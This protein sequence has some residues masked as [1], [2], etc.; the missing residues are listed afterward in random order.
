MC[1]CKAGYAGNGFGE[2]GCLVATSD[3]CNFVRCRNGGTCV[4][5]DTTA[6]C[7]CPAGTFPPLCD[8]LSNACASS[9]CKNGGN[10]TN[11]RFG[12]KYNCA[13]IKGFNGI[14]CQNQVRRCGGIRDTEN[15]TIRYPE[16]ASQNY[17]HNSRCAWLIKTNSSKVLKVTFSKFD[18]ELSSD[19]KFDW[20]QV[21]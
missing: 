11:T 1:I 17:A 3:P 9:P 13:C 5:N 18:L 10:C 21:G 14:N 16:I 15:G 2:N 19:C 7:Q 8:R 20:L 6:Y 4:R 12:R